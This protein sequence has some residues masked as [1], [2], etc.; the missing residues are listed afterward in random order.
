MGTTKYPLITISGPPASGTSTL[1][2]QLEE[3]LNFE[4]INGGDIFRQIAKDRDMSVGELNEYAKSTDKIDKELDSRLKEIIIN[5]LSRER[6]PE[7]KGLII[8]S[9]LAAWHAEGDAT[10]SIYLTAPA[11]IRAERTSNRKETASAL[12]QREKAEQ[13]RYEKYYGIDVTD[14]TVYDVIINTK[15]NSIQDTVDEA[16]SAFNQTENLVS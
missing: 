5:H 10:L 4:L 7:G 9:R 1:S 3:K 11:K 15:D 13:E 14:K 2:S 8:E 6:K 12:K 16:L